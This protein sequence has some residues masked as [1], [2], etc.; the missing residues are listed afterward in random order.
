MRNLKQRRIPGLRQRTI[1]AVLALAVV[2]ELAVTASSLAQAQTYSETTLFVFSNCSLDGCWANM[3][4]LPDAAGNL[5]GTTMRGGSNGGL[6]TV[7]E[8]DSAGTEIVL[9]GFTGNAD[10]SEPNPGLVADK[11]GNFYGTTLFGGGS[12]QGTVFK[13]SK[14]GKE[15]VLMSFDGKNGSVP[16]AGLVVDAAGNLYGTTTAGGYNGENGYGTVF[17]VS[18]SGKETLLYQ[19][20]G[21]SDG[22]AP[23]GP[24][25]RDD[26]GN[27]YG[28]TVAGGASGN[29]DCGTVFKLSPP[30]KSGGRWTER[31]LHIFDAHDGQDGSEPYAGLVRDVDG[32][33]YGTTAYG[34][35]YG[36]GTVFKLTKGGK[37]TVLHSF[38]GNDGENPYSGLVRDSSGNLYGAATYGGINN[39]NDENGDLGCGTVFKVDTHG[40]ETVL[41]SFTGGTDGAYPL[42]GNLLRDAEGNLY[43]A[44]CGCPGN[45]SL[46]FKLVP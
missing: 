44:T 13:V 16:A 41:Y 19:F 39:C 15:T 46:I 6:G 29:C 18:N 45:T 42:Y 25:I 8:I 32:N 2:F 35:T 28:T 30:K 27:L 14:Q 37:E 31:V 24:L 43:G 36:Y 21:G 9:Y 33:L 40:K 17:K 38:S 34:G 10:G 12:G 7:F 26:K 23:G 3:S 5:Y 20:R 4:L 1:S 22:R 11:A